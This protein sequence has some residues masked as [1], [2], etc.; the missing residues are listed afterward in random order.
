MIEALML[1]AALQSGPDHL[2][3]PVVED[4]VEEVSTSRSHTRVAFS[5]H[6]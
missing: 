1:T 5:D 6:H 2:V 4:K 3:T